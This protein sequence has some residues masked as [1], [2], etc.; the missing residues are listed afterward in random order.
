MSKLSA[1]QG[2]PKVYKIG[3]IELEL[4]PLRLDD[5]NL[6]TVD[7]D[8]SAKEQTESSLKLINKVL[9]DSVPDSTEEERK[10]IGLEY[11]EELMNAVMDVNGLKDQKGSAIDVI[12]ARQAQIQTPR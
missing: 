4:K 7:K 10:N 2:K 5:M 3:E 11:M 9:A 12:K 6:F 1:L 8:A